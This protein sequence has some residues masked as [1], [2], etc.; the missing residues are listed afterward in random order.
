MKKNNDDI[1]LKSLVGVSP[2]KKSNK[3]SKELPIQRD[4]QPNKSQ[5]NK[6]KA[7]SQNTPSTNKKNTC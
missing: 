1:F 2:L 7:T 3:V 4:P 5:T 6:T